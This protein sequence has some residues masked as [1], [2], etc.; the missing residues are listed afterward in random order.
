MKTSINLNKLL[1]STLCFF[2]ANCFAVQIAKAPILF[3]GKD[4]VTFDAV[5]EKDLGKAGFGFSGLNDCT[6]KI[7]E[8]AGQKVLNDSKAQFDPETKQVGGIYF[9]VDFN[10]Y[11]YVK[12]VLSEKYGEAQSEKFSSAIYWYGDKDGNSFIYISKS[13][14]M[15]PLIGG[16]ASNKGATNLVII[17]KEMRQVM[18]ESARKAEIKDKKDKEKAVRGL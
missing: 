3:Q 9:K 5:C 18:N 6:L 12:S 2:T 1:I 11:E 7:K 16:T 8:Y 15:G 13:D 4:A 10:S 14:P 17:T